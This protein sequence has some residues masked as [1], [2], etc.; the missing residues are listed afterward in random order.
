MMKTSLLILATSLLGACSAALPPI[1]HI[2]VAPACPLASSDWQAWVN[3]MPG[4]GARPT[5]IVTGKATVPTGGWT[6]AWRDVRVMESYPVQVAVDLEAILPNGGATQ[7]VVA[8]ELRG[9]WP[10]SPPVGSVTVQ[11]GGA[12]LARIAPVETAH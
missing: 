11:C 5:L 10:I 3:A 12:V 2:P 6:F 7:A 1:S 9:E 4:P 8:H